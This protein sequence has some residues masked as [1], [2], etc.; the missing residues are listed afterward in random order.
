MPTTSAPFLLKD[1]TFSLWPTGSAASGKVEYR[2]QLSQAEIQPQGGTT[3]DQ[4]YSTFCE[5]FTNSSA[6]ATY[7]LVLAGFQAYKDATDLSMLLWTEAGEEY[8]FLLVPERGTLSATHP[9]F[10]GTVTR[11][12]G[13]AGGT[14]KT[15]ATMTVTLVC[16]SKPALVT[17][18]PVAALFGA[19]TGTGSEWGQE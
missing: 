7:N 11:S 16:K 19:N 8:D 1:T 6:S 2:C 13:N 17:V 18:D 10:H 15:Y 9:G 12:E 3:G 14:A 4:T 5:D